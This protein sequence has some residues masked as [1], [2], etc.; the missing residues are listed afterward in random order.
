M[1]SSSVSNSMANMLLWDDTFVLAFTIPSHS[2]WLF[3]G[4]E[5]VSLDNIS[6][7]PSPPGLVCSVMLRTNVELNDAVMF[8]CLLCILNFR[9]YHTLPDKFVIGAPQASFVTWMALKSIS[10]S[11]V[12]INSFLL[13]SGKWEKLKF[14][15]STWEIKPLRR[16]IVITRRDNKWLQKFI[17]YSAFS[18]M[19][20]TA[21]DLDFLLDSWWTETILVIVHYEQITGWWTGFFARGLLPVSR[22]VA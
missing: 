21:T 5:L 9:L 15:P 14:N 10:A 11:G 18:K 4:T 19:I 3:S 2:P 16:G 8:F 12:R 17:L 22:F 13:L 1:F 7:S 20:E 6:A